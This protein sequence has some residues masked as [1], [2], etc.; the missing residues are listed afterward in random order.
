MKRIGVGVLILLTALTSLSAQAAPPLR[1]QV[2]AQI[3]QTAVYAGDV[4]HYTVRAIHPANVE[5]VLDN[6]KKELLPV[7]P[8]SVRDID[9]RRGEWS[10]G[11]K[12]VE[13]VLSLAAYETGKA[14]LTIPPLQ[15]YYFVR[16]P[17]V[18][19]KESPVESVNVPAFKVGWRSTLV[20]ARLVPRE[21]KTLAARGFA[22]PL[23]LL[24]F[25]A[26]GV[27]SVIGYAAWRLWQRRHPEEAGRR[28]TREQ[29]ERIVQDGLA[30][31]RA[32]V[33]DD[34]RR[35]SAAIAAE[36]RRVL[37]ALFQ[38][39][40]LALTP[41]ETAAAL[42]RAGADPALA[43]EIKAVLSQCEEQQYGNDRDGARRPRTGLAQ[44]AE[45]IMQSPQLLSA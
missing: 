7:A 30:R 1:P 19:G 4:L 15:L 44:A 11:E 3:D 35:A 6:F 12:F 20:P 24:A 17:G 2:T 34:A 21:S 27:L 43:A 31:L 10:D 22:V 14:E 8:F 9:I 26:A 42:A 32:V 5:I 37:E 39:P 25:G 36:L 18:A 23:L 16:E 28:L 40:A 33:P 45:K 13:I 41:E 38:I 29:R